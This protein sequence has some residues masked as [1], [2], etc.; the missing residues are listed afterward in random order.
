M[1]VTKSYIHGKNAKV[2]QQ[3]TH[4]LPA[5]LFP[6]PSPSPPLHQAIIIN[7]NSVGSLDHPYGKGAW[8][9][10]ALREQSGK[11][12]CHLLRSELV[13]I[14]HESRAG[15]Q[16]IHERPKLDRRSEEL[17]SEIFRG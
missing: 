15:V 14:R 2:A 1:K 17:R 7:V 4:S 5:S 16:D 13:R 10:R 6:L 11:V 8:D 9:D 12:G 3:P